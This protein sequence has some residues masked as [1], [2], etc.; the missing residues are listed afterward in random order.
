MYTPLPGSLADRVIAW[1]R[2]NPEEELMRSDIASKFD[3][4][5]NTIE[6]SLATAMSNKLIAKGKCTETGATIFKAGP[7]ISQAAASL[8]AAEQRKP[9]K[10][11]GARQR[12]PL[13]D[14]SAIQ[15]RHDV[16][17]PAAIAFQRTAGQY[18]Q[19]L[20][21]LDKPN[22]STE[23]PIAYR[24]AI[25]KA[26]AKYCKDNPSVKLVVRTLNENTIGIWRTA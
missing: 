7:N 19:L 9:S 23:L 3:C 18:A 14:L 10:R 20:A 6:A 15:V 13:L 2:I 17:P 11:G 26:A 5:S 25:T 21:K 8:P 22:A 1:F 4:Q 24:G 12:L 16:P